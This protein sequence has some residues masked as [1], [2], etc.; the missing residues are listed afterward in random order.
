MAGNGLP[1]RRPVRFR[2]NNRGNCPVGPGL[3]M[4]LGPVDVYDQF[5]EDGLIGRP[6]VLGPGNV[7][8]FEDPVGWQ[9]VRLVSGPGTW[10]GGMDYGSR[11]ELRDG[12]MVGM[13]VGPLR[14]KGG[15]HMR[16]HSP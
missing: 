1:G 12:D 14:R 8:Q 2:V 4:T 13:A 7:I 10:M 11:R 3:G 9:R 5:A 6:L 15:H 16:F